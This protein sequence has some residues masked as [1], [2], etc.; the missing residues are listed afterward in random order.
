MIPSDRQARVEPQS[1]NE[2]TDSEDQFPKTRRN[3][4]RVLLPEQTLCRPLGKIAPD[5]VFRE[6]GIL[7]VLERG[8]RYQPL[9]R[10]FRKGTDRKWENHLRGRDAEDVGIAGSVQIIPTDLEFYHIHPYI[11][12]SAR[13][14]VPIGVPGCRMIGR[15]NEMSHDPL[16]VRLN[17]T[18]EGEAGPNNHKLRLQIHDG[19]RR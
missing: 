14:D 10:I 12:P 13:S 6:Y 15:K 4:R 19:D 3:G 16:D 17:R 8:R 7:G 2:V 5:D 11:V 1:H 18:G 9:P